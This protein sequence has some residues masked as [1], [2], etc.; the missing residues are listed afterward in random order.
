MKFKSKVLAL[1]SAG[2]SVL[3]A[4]A[5]FAILVWTTNTG[6][7]NIPGLTATT[8]DNMA[9][10]A[11]TPASVAA[12]TLS[13]SGAVSGAGITARFATPGPIGNTSPST[14][15]F[16]TLAAT[17]GPTING[18]AGTMCAT[19]NPAT[20]VD[21]VFYTATR[22]VLVVAISEVHAVAAGG[23]SVL[24]V[25]KDTSTNAPGA[26]T[27]L[28]T[29]NT[30]TGFDLNATANTVQVG[31]LVA[32]GTRTLAAGDRLAYDFANAIQSSAG[33]NITVCMQP[34]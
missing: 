31:T 19:A 29:N 18:D 14:G 24:Q 12:T 7:V 34:L 32:A 13:A 23:A 6:D 25:V 3:I 22:P 21:A 2:L 16:T 15:A 30:N 33:I 17:S 9:I 1:I 5:A 8:I 27:D 11:T 10:G 26:G 20:A 4:P 28:L